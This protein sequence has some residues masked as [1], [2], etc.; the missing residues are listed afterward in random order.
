MITQFLTKSLSG[1]IP[2][3]EGNEITYPGTSMY[4]AL[5][6]GDR[7]IL[8]LNSSVKIG[9]IIVF[10]DRKQCLYTIHRIINVKNGV[11]ETAGDN[12]K[13]PD[14]TSICISDVTGKVIA[15]RRCER[16]FRV[17]GGMYGRIYHWYIT[18]IHSNIRLFL[19]FLKP[20]YY[21]VA[22][23]AVI[24][25]ILSPLF[26]LTLVAQLKNGNIE[27]RLFLNTFYIGL[28]RGESRPWIIRAPLRLLVDP[29]RLPRYET[30]VLNAMKEN[31]NKAP[32]ELKGFC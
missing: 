4:P 24:G 27:V 9:D 12:N 17:R 32:G 18:S 21:F 8:S 30:I 1:I 31:L 25:R 20:G 11:L 29:G 3:I 6:E 14:Q 2:K 22:R 15:K 26:K 10:P 5:I 28:C 16:L 23:K 13:N 7:L 19:P